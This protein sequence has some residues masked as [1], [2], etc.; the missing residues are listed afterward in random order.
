VPTKHEITKEEQS[1]VNLK[2]LNKKWNSIYVEART[3]A[4]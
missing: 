2:L 1:K 3:E 4:I